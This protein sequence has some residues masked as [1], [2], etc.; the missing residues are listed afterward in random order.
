VQDILSWPW[1]LFLGDEAFPDTWHLFPS[2]SGDR[3]LGVY[4]W[5]VGARLPMDR[6]EC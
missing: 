1:V 3:A 6:L 2:V 4:G 5:A